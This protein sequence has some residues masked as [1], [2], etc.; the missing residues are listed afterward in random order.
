MRGLGK[1][2]KALTSERRFEERRGSMKFLSQ[3]T[4][5]FKVYV[6]PAQEEIEQ[7]LHRLNMLLLAYQQ[8][9][10]MTVAEWMA[11]EREIEMELQWFAIHRLKLMSTSYPIPL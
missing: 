8:V 10:T 11:T 6:P 9:K 5:W 4:S 7:H 2:E 1:K 3:L